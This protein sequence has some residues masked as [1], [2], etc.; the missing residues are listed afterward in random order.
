MSSAPATPGTPSTRASA[1]SPLAPADA[2]GAG[3]VV[4]QV[5][6][7]IGVAG[8]VFGGASLARDGGLPSVAL[9]ALI[10]LG[11]LLLSLAGTVGVRR[12][13]PTLV[14]AQEPLGRR[15]ARFAAALLGI[16][17]GWALTAL[18]LHATNL[19]LGWAPRLLLFALGTVAPAWAARAWLVRSNG[20]AD[21]PV[22]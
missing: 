8:V 6:L 1:E 3:L 18:A 11:G 17:C 22:V 16:G 20:N 9:A 2:R 19:S 14:R 5:G 4:V 13:P 10:A 12:A 15:R 21:L 7:G